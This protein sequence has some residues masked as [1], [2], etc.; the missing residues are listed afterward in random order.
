MLPLQKK[1]QIS[2]PN[3][4]DKLTGRSDL[5]AMGRERERERERELWERGPRGEK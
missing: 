4:Q 3:T 2:T 1:N 5:A